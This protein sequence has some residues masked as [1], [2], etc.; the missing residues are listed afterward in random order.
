MSAGRRAVTVTR[1]GAPERRRRSRRGSNRPTAEAS[2]K[3]VD[4][5]S[6]VEIAQPSTGFGGDERAGGVVPRL[7]PFS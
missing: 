2:M 1:R 7:R 5:R 4:R 6:A 3:S